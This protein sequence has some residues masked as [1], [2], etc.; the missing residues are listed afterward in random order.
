MLTFAFT[1]VPTIIVRPCFTNLQVLQQRGEVDP[2]EWRFLLAGPAAAPTPAPGARLRPGSAGA[3]DLANPS[4][5]WLTDKSWAD[6]VA[7]AA[8]PAFAGFDAHLAENEGHYHALFDSAQ[9]WNQ[10]GAKRGLWQCTCAA[11]P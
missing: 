2:R 1:G 10:L 7:L 3:V 6:V 4:G 11:M 9:V 5:G 8:L